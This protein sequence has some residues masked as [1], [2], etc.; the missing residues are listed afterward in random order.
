MESRQ[1]TRRFTGLT[2][3]ELL[4]VVAI[5]SILAMVAMPSYF[6]YL[7]RGH[8]ADVQSFLQEVVARQQHYLVDRRSYSASITDAASSGGLG[9]T[10]P[11]NVSNYYTLKLTTDNSTAPPT[12]TLEAEPKGD[13]V[14]D[15]CG[16]LTI[17]Q[18]GAKSAAGTGSCW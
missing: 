9:M 3:I 6:S 11:S 12:F 16:K 14:S 10:V 2:L 8:R 7:R 5:I 17:S 13:Q 1:L 15:P 4:I 18:A